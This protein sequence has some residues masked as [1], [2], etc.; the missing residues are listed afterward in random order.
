MNLEAMQL[1]ILVQ[2]Q[3]ILSKEFRGLGVDSRTLHLRKLYSFVNT[4]RSTNF[5]S[6]PVNILS[7]EKSK[8]S[9]LESF[10]SYKIMFIFYI[11]GAHGSVVG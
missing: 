11:F 8:K 10:N 9:S 5:S 6:F 2:S 4:V 3:W 7:S 1:K